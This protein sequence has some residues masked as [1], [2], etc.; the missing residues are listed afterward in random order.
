LELSS[1]AAAFA[2]DHYGLDVREGGIGSDVWGNR[3]FDVVTLFHVLE[4][5]PDP[6]T[7][8]LVVRSL[9]R[10]EGVLV[11]QVPNVDS[12]QARL[13]GRRWYGLDVP[14]HVVN[15]TAQS[16]ARLLARCGFENDRIGH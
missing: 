12:Y 9:L 11:A 10:A 2:R 3:T 5:L 8:L 15:F 1:Q 7:A 4:H 14:R 13:F 6:G 16:L